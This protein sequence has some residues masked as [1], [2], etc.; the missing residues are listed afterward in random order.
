[1]ILL[2][3]KKSTIQIN[4]LTENT[5]GAKFWVVNIKICFL[6]NIK[7]RVQKLIHLL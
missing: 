4:N 7:C 6:D 5:Y 2:N 1:M 3:L